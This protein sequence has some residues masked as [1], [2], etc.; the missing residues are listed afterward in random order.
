MI[1]NFLAQHLYYC[2]PKCTAWFSH[3]HVCV[4]VDWYFLY[5]FYV[6]TIVGGCMSVHCRLTY[7]FQIHCHTFKGG[8]NIRCYFWSQKW[9]SNIEELWAV[10]GYTCG[11]EPMN[12]ITV[13]EMS[14]FLSIFRTIVPVWLMDIYGVPKLNI[15]LHNIHHFTHKI[16]MFF[17]CHIYLYSYMYLW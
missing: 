14:C 3:L 1:N 16:Y 7:L 5:K 4:H 10:E 13:V 17:Y 15:S 2:I 11:Y 12:N 9:V 8:P 6:Q